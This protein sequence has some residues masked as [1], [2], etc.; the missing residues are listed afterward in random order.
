[1]NKRIK[2]EGKENFILCLPLQVTKQQADIL[3]KR[4]S[5]CCG[6]Y[7]N[8]QKK[9]LRKFNY[10]KQMKA[11]KEC[12]TLSERRKFLNGYT[13]Q[14]KNTKGKLYDLKPFTEFGFKSYI[15]VFNE[16]FSN[17]GI[18][19]KLLQYIASNA[20]SAWDKVLYGKGKRISFKKKDEFNSYTIGISSN[21]TFNGIDISKLN[22][23]KIGVNLNGGRG[24]NAK[25]IYIPYK[26]NTDYERECFLNDIRAIGLKR[27]FIRGKWKYFITFSFEGK[28]PVKN[29]KLG[30]GKVGIDIGPS[31]IA[32]SSDDVVYMDVLAKNVNSIEDK[33]RL[34][35]RKIDRSKRKTNP[36]Q[37]K[38]DGSIRRYKKGERPKWIISNHCKDYYAKLK[39]LYRKQSVYR[40]NSHIELSNMLL[41]LGNDFI[42]ENNPVEAWMRKSKEITF[43]KKGKI[44]SRKRFGKSIA[45]HAPSMFITIL[46]NKVKSLGGS[47]TKAD[48]K[49]AAS[50]FDFTNKTFT[51]HEL[52]ERRI[53]LSNGNT[54]CRD[55]IAAFN[56]QHL[57]GDKEYDVSTMKEK[58]NKFCRMEQEEIKRHQ[59][60]DEKISS[61]FGIN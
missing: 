56:L 5:I 43:N 31:T 54:H 10:V 8:F 39:E 7:N 58:Y 3:N 49:N 30:K 4:L 1:M 22:E 55:S 50:Q 18:N 12:K 45:N 21:N 13:I 2:E 41:N 57:I 52:K 25:V 15:A 28:K 14:W 36:L 40:K 37:F 51:K 48:I 32:I 26:I 23:N 61:N 29:R 59:M 34:L 38:E 19:S 16:T 47:L 46:E 53:N 27:V 35:Q 44:N 42:V 9:M 17:N 20:W 24:K 60:F 33:K 11:Y 6:I